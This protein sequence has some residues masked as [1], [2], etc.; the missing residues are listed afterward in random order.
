MIDIILAIATISSI[1]YFIILFALLSG[2]LK[3]SSKISNYT[4]KVSIVVSARNESKNIGNLLDD[5]LKQKYDK[6]LI[7]II[8]VNDRSEDDTGDILNRYANIHRIIKIVTINKTYSSLSPKKYAISKAIEIAKGD[9]ILS[10]DADC[11]LNKLWLHSMVSYFSPEVGAVAGGVILHPTKWIFS[12]LMTI[13][14]IMNNL[15]IDGSLGWNFPMACKGGNF[16]YRR[17]V[18]Y[19]VGGFTGLEKSLSGDDDL[20]LQKISRMSNWKIRN[21]MNRGAL[22]E[23]FAPSNAA[24]FLSQRKRHISASKYFSKNIQFIYSMYFFSKLFM[25]ISFLWILFNI[26]INNPISYFILFLYSLTLIM[27][28]DV[29]KNNMQKKYLLFY[30]LWELYYLL[31]H[32]IL[33]PFALLGKVK[34]GER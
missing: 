33:A 17:C 8:V 32:I 23:S 12:Y 14:A 29:S 11:R 5:L 6:D 16:A 13:D 30:P 31:N 19:E 20:L 24:H 21:C 18:Y 15:I 34:W 28:L 22:V 9:I 10:T 4:Y 2:I 27:L 26:G 7:E 25:F 1:V 3:S